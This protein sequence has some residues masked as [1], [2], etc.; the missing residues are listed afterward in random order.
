M[1][2]RFNLARRLLIVLVLITMF[3][4]NLLA[5]DVRRGWGYAYGGVGGTN[6]GNS[7]HVGGGGTLLVAGGFGLEGEL[8]HH[9]ATADHFDNSVRIIS[10]NMAYHFRGRDLSK[11][12]IPF[13]SGGLS[14]ADGRSGG[15]NFGFG[16][17]YWAYER[18]ALR[19]EFREHIFSSDSPFIHGFHIGL[20]FR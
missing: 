5:Q 15:G 19:L 7:V 11:R 17:Q 10:A 12:L 1:I 18:I 16:I 6:Q 4:A 3:T 8:G 2:E 9:G 14:L 20:A 13:A